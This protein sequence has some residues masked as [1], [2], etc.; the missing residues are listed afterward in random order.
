MEQPDGD[1]QLHIRTQNHVDQRVQSLT[2]SG[3]R[4]IYLVVVSFGSCVGIGSSI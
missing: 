2:V 1:T 4:D 3:H